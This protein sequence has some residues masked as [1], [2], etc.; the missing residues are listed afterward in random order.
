MDDIRT[1][2]AVLQAFYKQYHGLPGK[3]EETDLQRG[4]LTTIF[5][6]KD[7]LQQFLSATEER[8]ELQEEILKNIGSI[9]NLRNTEEMQELFAKGYRADTLGR[10]IEG[11]Y[12]YVTWNERMYAIL[13]VLESLPNLVRTQDDFGRERRIRKKDPDHDTLFDSDEDDME[14]YESG[15]D[16]E[17]NGRRTLRDAKLICNLL[18]RLQFI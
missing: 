18:R 6:L 10:P 12:A 13:D 15:G 9:L 17:L 7:E 4:Y 2:I 14:E 8:D 5:E 16:Q 1:C 3:I 11:P